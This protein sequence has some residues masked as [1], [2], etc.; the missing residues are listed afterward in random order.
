MKVD[1]YYFLTTTGT[2]FKREIIIGLQLD[3]RSSK[4][5]F[6]SLHFVLGHYSLRGVLFYLF[7]IKV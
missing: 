2:V 5:C 6:A 3:S 7:F 1:S 4:F